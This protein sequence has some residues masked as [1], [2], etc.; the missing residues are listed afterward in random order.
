MD[1]RRAV[2]AGSWYPGTIAEC[3][4][5]ILGFLKE[6][7]KVKPEKQAV[8]VIVPHA[9]WVYSGG[10]ACRAI[11]LLARKPLPETIVVFGMH[12][13]PGAQPRIMAAGGIET[14]LGALEVDEAITRPL[15]ERFSFQEE[16]TRRFSQDNTI[17]LQLPFIKHFFRDAQIV[18]I[19]VPPNPAAVE[20]GAA[21]VAIA[22]EIGRNIAVV[23]STDLTHYGANFSMT[24]YGFGQEAHE[25]VRDREDRRIIERMLA[26][27][28]LPVIREALASSNACC[29]GAAAAA[30]SA[31]KA[32]GATE[33]ALT[34]YATSYDK[35]PGESFVGYAGI[36]FL[37]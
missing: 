1:V 9:G 20:I 30:I 2:F 7:V 36:V 4:R 35:S 6:G 3:E 37:K 26:M 19:G 27:D 21:V 15:L 14:P 12:L 28:P 23:G 16:T 5:Q 25:K 8:G 31:A 32:L 34:E 18:P 29:S 13:P 17:E 24:H 10:I 11:S 33:A 22:N